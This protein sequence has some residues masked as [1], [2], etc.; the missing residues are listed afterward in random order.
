MDSKK[1]NLFS[2]LTTTSFSFPNRIAMAALTRMRCDYN[3][4]VPNELHVKYYSERARKCAF[5]LTECTSISKLGNN[6]PGACGIYTD[7]Q[8]EGWKKVIDA[9]HKEGGKIFLQIWHCGRAGHSNDGGLPVA[10]SP[11][12]LKGQAHTSKGKADYEVPHELTIEEIKEIVE[13]FRKGAENAQ[14]AGF[15]GLELHAANGYLVDEFLRDGTNKRTDI[16]GGSI[17]NR[18]RFCLE[19]TDALISVYGKDKVGLKLCPLGRYQDMFDSDPKALYFYLLKQLSDRN[20]LFIEL[21]ECDAVMFGKE[22]DDQIREFAKE[23]T[24]ASIFRKY[25]NGIYVTNC[26]WTKETG[27]QII[28]EGHAD[29]VTFGRLFLANPDLVERFQNNWELN[30]GN[31]KTWFTPGAEGY[32]DYPFYEKN[33]GNI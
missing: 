2:P 31:V 18:S 29:M 26:G 3:T 15:D 5:V 6:F 12:P 28:E 27:N 14:K 17:E 21:A 16:Y 4:C 23:G 19:V 11:I 20:V 25:F 24:L 1:A 7:E 32:T 9:V 33:N 10:P 30:E 13:Q 8:V 22:I